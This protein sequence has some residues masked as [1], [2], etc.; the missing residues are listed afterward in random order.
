MKENTGDKKGQLNL[1]Y[2]RC[3]YAQA[4]SSKN[5]EDFEKTQQ[6]LL[7]SVDRLENNVTVYYNQALVYLKMLQFCNFEKT[8]ISNILSQVNEL[9]QAI[10]QSLEKD[11]N[12]NKL[13]GND[14]LD[15][16]ISSYENA[17]SHLKQ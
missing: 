5:R 9:I 13:L 15:F 2:A 1:L 16:L 8:E 3:W 11:R 7:A 12:S 17:K 6:T 14:R 4:L 10:N